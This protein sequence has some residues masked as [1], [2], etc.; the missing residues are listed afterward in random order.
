VV[1]GLG[2]YGRG[3]G[4]VDHRG[5]PA[6]GLPGL[7]CAF[8][9][10]PSGTWEAGSFD[11]KH[12]RTAHLKPESGYTVHWDDAAKAPILY[13]AADQVFITFDDAVAVSWKADYALK[14]GLGGVMIWELSQDHEGELLTKICEYLG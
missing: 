7:G 10:V 2:F 13:S 8:S 11:Y 4:A 6:A 12:L 9:G 3:F 1:L 14:R 5:S